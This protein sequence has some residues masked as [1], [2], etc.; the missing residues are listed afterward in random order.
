MFTQAEVFFFAQKFGRIM[1]ILLAT[2][3]A[4][5]LSA[6]I[7]K[8]ARL[9]SAKINRLSDA[10]Q[11]RLK[12]IRSL[13]LNTVKF[14]INFIAFLMVLSEAG[15]NILPLIAGAGVLGMAV[16]LGAKE[17][18][19]DLIAGFFII[20]ENQFNVGDQIELGASKGKVVRLSLRTVTLKDKSGQTHIIPN[21]TIKT[22][23]VKK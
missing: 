15:V 16:G 4:K 22:V 8:K 2:A 3:I 19:S 13:L 18:V 17:L 6:A 11:Q 9:V 12:T 1:G 10:Q 23:I 21:S 14:I 7:I 20:M 5:N